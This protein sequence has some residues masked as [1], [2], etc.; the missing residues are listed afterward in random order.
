M[1]KYVILTIILFVCSFIFLACSKNTESEREDENNMEENSTSREESKLTSDPMKIVKDDSYDILEDGMAELEII[2]KYV[3]DH[4]DENGIVTLE[5]SGYIVRVALI[6]VHDPVVDEKLIYVIGE[7]KNTNDD[8]GAMRIPESDIKTKEATL[9]DTFTTGYIEPN[10]KD[11]F[12]NKILLNG[13]ELTDSFEITFKE[14]IDKDDYSD[15][16]DANDDQVKDWKEIK[17]HKK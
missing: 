2:E 8:G 6:L 16:S 12:T 5:K 17:F 11:T 15:E 4:S 7:H 13:N 9:E 14:P 3:N 1:K 10:A